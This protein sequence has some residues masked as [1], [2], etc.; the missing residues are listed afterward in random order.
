MYKRQLLDISIGLEELS[1][2]KE[3]HIVSVNNDV[4]ELLWIMNRDFSGEVNI[5][6]INF[7]KSNIQTFSLSLVQEKK[8]VSVYSL[9][10][11]YLYEPN[12]SILKSGAFKSVGLEFGLIKLHP[13]THLYTSEKLVDFPGRRFKVLEVV[14]YNSK[15]IKRLQIN[16]ANITTRNFPDSVATIRKKFKINEGGDSFLFFFKNTNDRYEAVL[17]KKI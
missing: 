8:A 5:R 9:P 10:L 16:K 17:C 11:T 14:P 4:K 13:N 6:T 7:A 15:A 3:I 1:G 12:A 2:V